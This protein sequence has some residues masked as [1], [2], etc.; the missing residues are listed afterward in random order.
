MAPWVFPLVC[1]NCINPSANT[2]DDIG[3]F[4]IRTW[5]PLVHSLAFA[6]VAP[7]AGHVSDLVG[8][9]YIAI[10]ATVIIIVGMVVVGTAHRM[11]VAIIGMALGGMGGG[12]GGTVAVAAVLE[13]VPVNMRGRY[14]GTIFLIFLPMAPSVAYGTSY[15]HLFDHLICS[16]NVFGYPN[17]ALER[18]DPT[19]HRRSRV[20]LAGHPIP[21][22]SSTRS[23]RL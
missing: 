20:G 12:I 2:V 13:M 17:L 7:F 1:A 22:S 21:T 4:S 3:G 14:L 16:A 11:A 8:R 5:L 18:M 6:A 9:R 19:C 10:A 23:S 15:L